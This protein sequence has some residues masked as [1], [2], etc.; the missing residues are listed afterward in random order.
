M[1]TAS[2]GAFVS[3]DIGISQIKEAKDRSATKVT[4]I[5]LPDAPPTGSAPETISKE[6]PELLN[7]TASGTSYPKSRIDL[8]DRFID[9]P[10]A[11]RVAVIGGGLAGILAGILLPVK[12]PNIKLTIYEKNHDLVR[13]SPGMILGYDLTCV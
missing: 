13:R 12:V 2:N 1:T 3:H 6:A 4:P 8:L 10:R 7:G 5:G 9:E 11:L